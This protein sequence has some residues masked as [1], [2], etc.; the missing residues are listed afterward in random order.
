MVNHTKLGEDHC[1]SC[2]KLLD[3][4]TSLEEGAVP[5]PGDISVCIYCGEFLLYGDD[6]ALEI[7]P[8]VI[9]DQLETELKIQLI[10]IRKAAADIRRTDIQKN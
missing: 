2:K 3:A 4:A 7:L 8:K 10:G 6:M 5:N 9:W 1:P